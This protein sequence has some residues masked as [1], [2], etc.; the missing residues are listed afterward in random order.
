MELSGYKWRDEAVEAVVVR[1]CFGDRDPDVLKI[2]SSATSNDKTAVAKL[3]KWMK[4]RL[5]KVGRQRIEDIVLVH[6][7]CGIIDTFLDVCACMEEGASFE[8][9]R[10]NNILMWRTFH[11]NGAL[12]A[13]VKTDLLKSEVDTIV[14]GCTDI[15][16]PEARAQV[17]EGIFRHLDAYETMPYAPVECT[18]R[19]LIGS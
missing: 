14:T 2:L 13:E 15:L 4:E 17:R 1:F 3:K 16:T 5:V 10:L 19:K 9:D 18:H 12:E 11:A 8:Y 6:V 7:C